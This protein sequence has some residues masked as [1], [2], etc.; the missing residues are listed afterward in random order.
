MD[1]DRPGAAQADEGRQ[2]IE[3]Y[4][5]KVPAPRRAALED[6]RR[7]IRAAAPEAVEAIVY[8]MPG[9]R[10]RGQ[11]LVSYAAWAR[12]NAFYPLSASVQAAHADA[13]AAGGL[14]ASK[15]TIQFG[16][17]DRMPAVIVEAT[18]RERMAAIDQRKA[19]TDGGAG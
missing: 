8:S 5:A 12:H 11:F 10:Y 14:R 17:T 13:F 18:L 7:T 16:P 19:A 3:A 2:A 9:F 6:L 1:S 15:G 4:L